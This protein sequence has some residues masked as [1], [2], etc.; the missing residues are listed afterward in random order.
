MTGERVFPPASSPD[1]PVSG[2]TSLIAV[3]RQ[4]LQDPPSWPGNG[5]SIKPIFYITVSAPNEKTNCQ[6]SPF[7][8]GLEKVRW[9]EIKKSISFLARL[10]LPSRVRTKLNEEE[11]IF[12]KL[13]EDDSIE[14]SRSHM[15]LNM[16]P[17][18]YE[19]SRKNVLQ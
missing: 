4:G 18:F 19:V 8:M 16:T 11:K 17:S 10:D 12:G 1:H 3:G 13:S 14:D 15:Q 5:L 9:T 6:F 7:Y 2:V